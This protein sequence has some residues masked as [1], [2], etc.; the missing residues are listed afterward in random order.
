MQQVLTDAE[1]WKESILIYFDNAF[2]AGKS[3]DETLSE[4][5]QI[6]HGTDLGNMNYTIE[7]IMTEWKMDRGML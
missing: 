4:V 1:I 5:K 2:S 7:S 6:V 3:L